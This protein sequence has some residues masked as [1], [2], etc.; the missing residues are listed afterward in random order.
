MVDFLTNTQQFVLRTRKK[1]RESWFIIWV[2]LII[3]T[4]VKL[5]VIIF[6]IQLYCILPN[7]WDC[8]ASFCSSVWTFQVCYQRSFFFPWRSLRR[9]GTDQMLR[10]TRVQSYEYNYLSTPAL[11]K[12]LKGGTMIN[13]FWWDLCPRFDGVFWLQKKISNLDQILIN[14]LV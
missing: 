7:L 8:F 2:L 4:P 14:L 1:D 9:L 11:T 5:F 6:Y 12:Y 10:L 3:S 13:N